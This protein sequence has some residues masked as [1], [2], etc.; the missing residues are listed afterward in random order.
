MF[1]PPSIQLKQ[2]FEALLGRQ[3]LIV[4]FISPVALLERLKSWIILFI[5][6]PPVGI[7]GLP[8][9]TGDKR[10]MVDGGTRA[11]GGMTMPKRSRRA[12]ATSVSSARSSSCRAVS[13]T[14]TS[15]ILLIHAR[16][17]GVASTQMR[18]CVN[19]EL[20]EV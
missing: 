4:S 20:G 13:S 6:T 14:V 19:G 5:L 11:E 9:R 1:R 8:A 7:Y 15:R 2:D 3:A 17:C 18:P 12:S 10:S 16:P